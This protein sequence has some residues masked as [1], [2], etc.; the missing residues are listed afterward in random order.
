[1]GFSVLG[2]L[3]LGLQAVPE[4]LQP[5]N[6]ADFVVFEREVA[7]PV[8]EGESLRLYDVHIAIMYDRT[9]NWCEQEGF[10]E[11][12]TWTYAADGGNLILG[13]FAISCREARRVSRRYGLDSA[14]EFM[15]PERRQ[16]RWQRFVNRLHPL[17]DSESDLS[18]P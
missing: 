15:V 9:H 18:L 1:M 14:L 4:A 12:L 11:Q 6:V 3:L 10:R 17:T 7:E 8:S 16:S 13:E 2:L 5:K